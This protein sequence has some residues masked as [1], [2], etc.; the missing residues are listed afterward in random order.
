[1]SPRRFRL[2]GATLAEVKQKVVDEHG[3]Q[4]RIIA[5]E[6]I[7][8]GG[9]AGFFAT[10]RYEVTVE[11]PDGPTPSVDAHDLSAPRRFGL[12]ALLDDADAEEAGHISDPAMPGS[13]PP[14][15]M[16]PPPSEDAARVA[17]RAAA[18]ARHTVA[19]ETA[20]AAADARRRTLDDLPI[21]A[22]AANLV[23]TSGR[24]FA[25]VLDGLQAVTELPEPLPGTI[26]T[27][28]PPRGL[29]SPPPLLA[30]PGDLIAVAG[31]PAD[32]LAVA[33][34]MAFS[35]DA[36]VVVCGTAVAEGIPRIDGRRE[37][38]TARAAA[39]QRDRIVIV[40]FGI[41]SA[42]ADTRE[43]L[44]GRSQALAALTADQL[45]LAVDAGRKPDDT[46]RWVAAV[47][48]AS[49]PD[50]VAG[51]GR[52]DTATPDTVR[53]LGYAVSWSYGS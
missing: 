1:M 39:V 36:D 9:V 52:D 4:A 8:T 15:A 35:V 34:A 45:W 22:D 7:T 43:V 14:A 49:T 42:G 46:E 12:A 11:V 29:P 40:A 41:S 25:A 27:S 37:A 31:L 44:A 2:D 47:A 3:P 51:I 20:A 18:D 30:G 38:I 19:R 13:I 26:S 6:Q 33:R 24:S 50:A 53:E 32:A 10:R 5:A 21:V 17:A 23:S 16:A 28:E 48:S